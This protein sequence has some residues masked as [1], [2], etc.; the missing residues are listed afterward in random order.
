MAASHVVGLSPGQRA[1]MEVV[2]EL[3][4]ALESDGED[5]AL[6]ARKAESVLYAYPEEVVRWGK[7][8]S[9][10]IRKYPDHAD[11]K[12]KPEALLFELE[13]DG[14][15]ATLAVIDR[16]EKQVRRDAVSGFSN[17]LLSNPKRLSTPAGG[18]A[19]CRLACAAA[20]WDPTFVEPLANFAYE[21]LA[22]G[23][24]DFYMSRIDRVRSAAEFLSA[25]PDRWKLFWMDRLFN[26]PSDADWSDEESMEAIDVLKSRSA[27]KWPCHEA[28][29]RLLPAAIADSFSNLQA[30]EGSPATHSSGGAGVDVNWES[31][32]P[33]KRHRNSGRPHWEPPLPRPKS[34]ARVPSKSSPPKTEAAPRVAPPHAAPA[35]RTYSAEPSWE[36]DPNSSQRPASQPVW[37]S[38][39]SR[40]TGSSGSIPKWPMF[41]AISLIVKL[42]LLIPHCNGS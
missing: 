14:N 16:F 35:A 33:S 42:L 13:N 30:V 22:R 28:L 39:Q 23:E 38:R 4:A 5:V 17:L 1:V 12:L 41:L 37:S 6:L 27:H 36:S 18:L 25:V 40:P 11:L 31:K 2:D 8:I 34:A 10:L 29:L 24:R 32:A 20:V 21:H 26:P 9:E 3:A 7:G 19:A 15:E